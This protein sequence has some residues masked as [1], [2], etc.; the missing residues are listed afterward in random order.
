MSDT[1]MLLSYAL[2]IVGGLVLQSLVVRGAEG[3]VESF[4][5]GLSVI[6]EFA[7]LKVISAWPSSA[8]D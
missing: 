6:G 8:G 3:T 4:L 7:L 5:L 2:V 1:L